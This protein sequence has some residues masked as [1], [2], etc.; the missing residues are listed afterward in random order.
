VSANRTSKPELATKLCFGLLLFLSTTA[1]LVRAELLPIKAYTAAA[2]GLAH[3]E[4]NKIVR[5]SR[6][7]LW[8]CTADGLSRFDGYTFT[9]FG[10]DQG[11]PHANVTDLLETRSGEYWVAT[12]G[13]IVRFNPKGAPGNR[14]FI[15]GVKKRRDF[16]RQPLFVE[17]AS[18]GANGLG[19]NAVE[20]Q[21]FNLGG[22]QAVAQGDRLEAP[23]IA[24]I[25]ECHEH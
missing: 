3:D 8:F 25:D 15:Q 10:T 5:D 2:A 4:I 23:H 13:G 24:G 11:L 18:G 22:D 14:V 6:G 20:V 7:F 1:S 17:A 12:Y 21:K 16:A 9:N 19:D